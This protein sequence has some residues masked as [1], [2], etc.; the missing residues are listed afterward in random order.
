MADSR[1]GAAQELALSDVIT[2]P[3]YDV[4]SGPGTA[5]GGLT[6]SPEV[7]T[8]ESTSGGLTSSRKTGYRVNSAS[9]T[10]AETPGTIPV[11]LGRNGKRFLVR[12]RPNGAG[13]GLAEVLFRGHSH[14]HPHHERA[15]SA[16]LRRRD[17]CGR[18]DRQVRSVVENF[19]SGLLAAMVIFA[20]AALIA[21]IAFGLGVSVGLGLDWLV[22]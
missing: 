19:G 5:F 7:G 4:L 18:R 3:S 8:D 20:V 1:S 2:T 9:F 17:G 10:I 6:V 14:H 11:L 13:S 22:R 16:R 12:W 21:G 15:R